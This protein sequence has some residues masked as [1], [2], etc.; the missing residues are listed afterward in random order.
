MFRLKR[1]IVGKSGIFLGI[2]IFMVLIF[3]LMFLALPNT[4]SEI[5]KTAER[6]GID[7]LRTDP[8]PEVASA[9]V[10]PNAGVTSNFLTTYFDP[11]DVGTISTPSSVSHP[12]PT[13]DMAYNESGN[14][15]FSKTATSFGFFLYLS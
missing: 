11:A 4:A 6:L 2:A 1:K 15:D 12:G 13:F 9:W 7:I 5:N 14:K 3:M 8:A 10:P